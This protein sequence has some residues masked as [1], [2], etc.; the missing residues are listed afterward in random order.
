MHE[1][2]ITVTGNTTAEVRAGET[3]DG[4]PTAN[5]TVA[6]P[7]AW[8]NRETGAF[9]DGTTSFWPVAVFG[10]QATYVAAS[11]AKGTRVVVTGT[12]A[13]RSW[14]D[15][16]SKRSRMEITASVVAISL[17]FGGR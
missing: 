11:V 14:D 3:T 10:P 9:E 2:T 1:T 7:P 17:L 13:E 12:V 16:G 4:K 8:L 5:F 6:S 15:N